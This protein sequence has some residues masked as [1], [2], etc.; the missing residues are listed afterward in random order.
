MGKVR[1]RVYDC[2]RNSGC[3][4][5]AFLSPEGTA[6]GGGPI[7]VPALVARGHQG[8][9]FLERSF[10]SLPFKLILPS[11]SFEP[12]LLLHHS[13][14]KSEQSLSCSHFCKT[15]RFHFIFAF[16]L[17]CAALQENL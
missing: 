17:R 2:L 14:R 5:V 1:K 3:Q 11:V 4:L 8:V 6:S 16:Y 9:V 7:L 10:S 13:G 12:Q 15:Q